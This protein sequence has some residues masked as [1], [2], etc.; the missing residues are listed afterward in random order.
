MR[1]NNDEYKA[2][3][4]GPRPSEDPKFTEW[5]S[6]LK[7][8]SS[9]TI[10][11]REAA[12]GGPDGRQMQDLQLLCE[13]ITV[14]SVRANVSTIAES[15]VLLAEIDGVYVG[16]CVSSLGAPDSDTLFIQVVSVVPT[17]R[18]RGVGI[19]LLAAAAKREPGRDIALATEATNSGAQALN[20]RF[21]ES[22]GA[23]IRKVPL[24]TY[25]KRDL[26]IQGVKG[27]GAW[28]IQRPPGE[29]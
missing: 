2:F 6:R 7:T 10:S 18:K 24:K 19:A 9:S 16:F 27:Y 12:T 20:S 15:L 8:L 3:E 29:P 17:A 26:G 22:I 11:V 1:V 28:V 5:T 21:G 4:Q 25:R 13:P 14:R 23:S